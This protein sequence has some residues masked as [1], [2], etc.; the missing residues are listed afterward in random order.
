MHT[1]SLLRDVQVNDILLPSQ[2]PAP[3]PQQAGFPFTLSTREG[4][5]GSNPTTPT[6]L[7]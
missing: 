7:P 5:V 1:T 4:V 2:I 3:L 6:F